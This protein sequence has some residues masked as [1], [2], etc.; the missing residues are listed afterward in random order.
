MPTRHWGWRMLHRACGPEMPRDKMDASDMHSRM[1][2][3][4]SNSNTPANVS[5]TSVAPNVP[6]RG[7]EQRMSGPER[8]K[9]QSDVSD[10]C[11]RVQSVAKESKRPTNKPERV[12]IPQNGYIMP[13]SSGASPESCPEEPQGPSN[14]ADASSTRTHTT[15]VESTQKRLQEHEKLSAYPKTSKNCRTH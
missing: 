9:I 15:A 12:R 7:A 6:A 11:S 2:S 8:L 10:V 13:N 4:A 14:H 5:V 3:V 1:Q